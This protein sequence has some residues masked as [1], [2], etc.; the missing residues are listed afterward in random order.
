MLF[1]CGFALCGGRPGGVVGR[2]MEVFGSV[3][4][5][6]RSCNFRG[7]EI[8]LIKWGAIGVLSSHFLS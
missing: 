2:G 7:G 5:V 6:V 4:V 3:M 8:I 1:V